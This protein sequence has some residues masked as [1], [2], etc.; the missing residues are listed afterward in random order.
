VNPSPKT[1]ANTH[2]VTHNLINQP[3]DMAPARSIEIVTTLLASAAGAGALAYAST[4][5]RRAAAAEG[6][7]AAAQVWLM[8]LCLGMANRDDVLCEAKHETHTIN[9]PLAPNKKRRRCST[10]RKSAKWSGAA[11]PTRRSSCAT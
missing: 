8:M 2:I 3:T 4:L 11:A 5:M 7:L 10:S 9:P 6:A 1:K